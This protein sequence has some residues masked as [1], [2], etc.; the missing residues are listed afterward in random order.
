M[1]IKKIIILC[2]S[3]IIPL[4]ITVLVALYSYG[5]IGTWTA[6]QKEFID[7]IYEQA[8][9]SAKKI[10]TFVKFNSVKYKNN[11]SNI[12]LYQDI[13]N[14]TELV[15]AN[16]NGEF[17]LDDFTMS[18]YILTGDD[19]YKKYAY[20]F[21]FYNIDNTEIDFS[22][23]SVVLI[24]PTD[25]NDVTL[26]RAE[27]EEYQRKFV[28]DS[29]SEDDK[30]SEIYIKNLDKISKNNF[31]TQGEF[32]EDING[33][34]K[35]I[36]GKA[37]N[38]LIYSFVPYNTFNNNKT[39]T[40]LNNCQFVIFNLEYDSSSNPVKAHVISSGKIENIENDANSFLSKNNDVLEGYGLGTLDA[41][42]K[43][44]YTSYILL[45]ILWQSAVCFAIVGFLGF[46]FYKSWDFEQ[47]IKYQSN[48]KK[49]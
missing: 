37:A 13:M 47:K 10:E 5:A 33:T 6:N 39:L 48:K 11:H 42:Q 27:I 3:I 23:I 20:N 9:T 36:E 26:L 22:N 38:R 45:N 25:I 15:S 21:Y 4:V 7:T 31:F 19:I 49:K 18:N 8:D 34:A 17:V 2:V 16:E 30:L 1:K 28:S 14:S 24:E 40:Q 41:I 12:K 32:L 43:I 29:T 35:I 44:G 46:M